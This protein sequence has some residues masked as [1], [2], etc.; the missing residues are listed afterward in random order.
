MPGA[1][2]VT[3]FGEDTKKEKEEEEA[4]LDNALAHLYRQLGARANYM[5]LDRSDRQVC[6]KEM[7]RRMAKPTLGNWRQVKRLARYLKGRPRVISR[8]LV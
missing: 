2:F 7:C 6:V 1:K 8:F 3:S 4:L 5:T